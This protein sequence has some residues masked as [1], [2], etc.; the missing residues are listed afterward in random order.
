MALSSR[1]ISFN[2]D[3]DELYLHDTLMDEFPALQNPGRYTLL[4]PNTNSHDLLSIKWP[5][6]GGITIRYL[7]EI[8]CSARLYVRP[9]QFD[10]LET[11]FEDIK[12]DER[13]CQVAAM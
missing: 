12:D 11:D 7:K 2:L 10:I 13:S 6:K 5:H 8:L 4:H 1:K 9:L 3:G